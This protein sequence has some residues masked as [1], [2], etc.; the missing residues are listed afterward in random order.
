MNKLGLQKTL[1]ESFF[2]KLVYTLQTV[3]VWI[4][5]DLESKQNTPT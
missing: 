1:K 5:F 4:L 3:K 2:H